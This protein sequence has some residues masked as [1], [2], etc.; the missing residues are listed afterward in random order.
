MHKKESYLLVRAFDFFSQSKFLVK[1][2]KAYSVKEG[3]RKKK[4]I[5][6][7]VWLIRCVDL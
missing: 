1:L 7:E 4:K 2:L 3:K 5:A 6:R